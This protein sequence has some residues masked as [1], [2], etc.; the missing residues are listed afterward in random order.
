GRAI[1]DGISVDEDVS[2]LAVSSLVN[3]ESSV[4]YAP[5]FP[6]VF[7]DV[8]SDLVRR[9]FSELDL[10]VLFNQLMVNLNKDVEW[11]AN[12]E[13]VLSQLGLVTLDDSSNRKLLSAHQDMV[14]CLSRKQASVFS[15]VFQAEQF[16]GSSHDS[17]SSDSLD[18]LHKKAEEARKRLNRVH[19][20]A[21]SRTR[22]LIACFDA[23]EQLTYKLQDVRTVL[24][25]LELATDVPD[26]KSPANHFLNLLNEDDLQA[27]ISRLKGT[28]TQAVNSVAEVK[29]LPHLARAFLGCVN[30][31]TKSKNAFREALHDRLDRTEKSK[32]VEEDEQLER[33][34]Y[35]TVREADDR[36]IYLI[37][38]TRE[39]LHRMLLV[40]DKYKD[41]IDELRGHR[42]TLDSIGK[43]FRS[44]D[45]RHTS[46]IQESELLSS[47][48][49]DQL[50]SETDALVELLTQLAPVEHALQMIQKDVFPRLCQQMIEACF[51]ESSVRELVARPLSTELKRA[52]QLR[53]AMDQESAERIRLLANHQTVADTL[54]AI[55]KCV[56]NVDQLLAAP[57]SDDLSVDY[58]A[59]NEADTRLA[60]QHMTLDVT[61]DRV[62]SILKEASREEGAMNK[63][64]WNTARVCTEQIDKLS[65]RLTAAT[66]QVHNRL[67][68][69][70]ASHDLLVKCRREATDLNRWIDLTL[71]L[72]DSPSFLRSSE[73]QLED[74]LNKIRAQIGPRKTQIS[75]IHHL[76]DML[77][78][79]THPAVNTELIAIV[80]D[81][82]S[83]LNQLEHKLD[84]VQQNL[85]SREARH[86]PYAAAV[87]AA[88]DWLVATEGTFNALSPIA[89]SSHELHRQLTEAEQ[90]VDRWKGYKDHMNE[91]YR[92]G[93]SYD[94]SLQFHDC[95]SV[96]TDGAVNP[97]SI[98]PSDVVR[99]MEV[100]R[101]RYA[102]LGT[103]L[104]ERQMEVQKTSKEVAALEQQ[105]QDLLSWLGKRVQ[106]L[107]GQSK[108]LISLQAVEDAITEAKNIHE[109]ISASMSGL[110][111][112]R[113]QASTILHNRGYV[114]GSSELRHAVTD[115][116]RHWSTA[117]NVATERRCR[118]EL[119]VKDAMDFASLGNK[120][121]QQLRQMCVAA[122]ALPPIDHTGLD[123]AP[124][125]LK[126]IRVL[127]KD[128]DSL[129]S[130]L[131]QLRVLGK[132][133]TDRLLPP[134]VAE[135]RVGQTIHELT[136]MY[137]QVKNELATKA[138]QYE[139]ILG[140]T[141]QFEQLLNRITDLVGHVQARVNDP[142][143][144]PTE[145]KEL[146]T[147]MEQ[148][149][150]LLH[151]A[152]ALCDKLC[153]V[154]T[155]PSLQFELKTKLLR[156][157][158]ICAQGD[159][160]VK[161]VLGESDL[162]DANDKEIRNQL[163]QLCGWM[164]EKTSQLDS[165]TDFLCQQTSGVYEV[166]PEM[167][168]Q[169]MN[170]LKT[171]EQELEQ[172]V[173][174]LRQVDSKP[175]VGSASVSQ[176]ELV[177]SQLELLGHAIASKQ[178]QLKSIDSEPAA[179]SVRLNQLELWIES[180]FAELAHPLQPSGAF[181]SEPTQLAASERRFASV[182]D[183]VH[184][185]QVDLE[186][187]RQKL[188]DMATTVEQKP[189]IDTLLAR[190]GVL[191]GSLA[192]L[193]ANTEKRLNQVST[194]RNS[195]NCAQEAVANYRR[196]V[197][198]TETRWISL[199]QGLLTVKSQEH[200]GVTPSA[201][202]DSSQKVELLNQLG[203]LQCELCILLDETAIPDASS[204][205]SPT[206]RVVQTLRQLE[207]ALKAGG[208]TDAR[209]SM[210]GLKSDIAATQQRIEAMVQSVTNDLGLSDGSLSANTTVNL[211]KRFNA[212]FRQ[213][214]AFKDRLSNFPT[215]APGMDPETVRERIQSLNEI[216]ED[217][218]TC[219]NTIGNLRNQLQS[220]TLEGAGVS[221]VPVTDLLNRLERLDEDTSRLD[222]QSRQQ[223]SELDDRLPRTEQLTALRRQLATVVDQAR[224][225][226]IQKSNGCLDTEGDTK[227]SSNTEELIR[228]MQKKLQA[229]RS[230]S[231]HLSGT[232]SDD[233]IQHQLE[234]E[235]TA[236]EH[237]VAQLTEQLTAQ[238][239]DQSDGNVSRLDQMSQNVM[240]LQGNFDKLR[241][242]FDEYSAQLVTSSDHSSARD[243]YRLLQTRVDSHSNSVD[244][245]VALLD[246]FVTND[247]QTAIRK[248]NLAKQLRGMQD[249]CKDLS[250]R[251]QV[252][253]QQSFNAEQTQQQLLDKIQTASAWLSETR[254]KFDHNE[255]AITELNSAADSQ[256]VA[257]VKAQ[258]KEARTN[259]HDELCISG[260]LT[261]VVRFEEHVPVLTDV[262]VPSRTTFILANDMC[263]TPDA[264]CNSLPG[265][266]Y[267][268][269]D[270]HDQFFCDAAAFE[271]W[272]SD[273][274]KQ[275]DC[276]Q[277]TFDEVQKNVRNMSS[278]KDLVKE[279]DARRKTFDSL[280]KEGDLL[281]SSNRVLDA[282]QIREK[283]SSLDDAYLE[284]R[285]D[286]HQRLSAL[287]T[288]LPIIQRLASALATLSLRLPAA[289]SRLATLR[290]NDEPINVKR[291]AVDQLETELTSVLN[292]QAQLV[293]TAWH[294]LQELC[295]PPF[296][297]ARVCVAS[298]RT[299]AEL[300]ASELERFDRFAEQV[301]ELAMTLNSTRHQTAAL[302]S[303]MDAEVLWLDAALKR[304]DPNSTESAPVVNQ[305]AADENQFTG[306]VDAAVELPSEDVD[307]FTKYPPLAVLPAQYESLIRLRDRLA[308][309][310]QGWTKRHAV[311]TGELLVKAHNLLQ[312]SGVRI[313]MPGALQ[314]TDKLSRQLL[315]AVD[316][317]TKRVAQL[318]TRVGQA[319]L[320]IAE[321]SPLAKSFHEDNTELA[322]WLNECEATLEQLTFPGNTA[323]LEEH[324]VAQDL[325]AEHKLHGKVKALDEKMETY[326]TVLDRIIRT[327]SPLIEL[328]GH[329][330]GSVIRAETVR[331][332]ERFNQLQKA[333]RARLVSVETSLKQSDE[334]AEQLNM[335]T[336]LFASIAEQASHLGVSVC[337]GSL[338]T[339]PS[340]TPIDLVDSAQKPDMFESV[341]LGPAVGWDRLRPMV[342]VQ[343]DQ[344]EDQ[345][346]ETKAL[347]EA[348]DQRL[349]ELE[350]LTNC[351]R[352]QLEPKL[353]THTAQRSQD[354][355]SSALVDP[356]TV[357]SARA[358]E[359]HKIILR[360]SEKL[361]T[362][363]LALRNQLQ[364]RV[365]KLSS[366]HE[367]AAKEFWPIVS[368]L[369]G[370]FLEAGETL[371][372]ITAGCR[373]DTPAIRRDPVDPASYVEQRADLENLMQTLAQL[374]AR[375]LAC[376][377]T[378][379]HLI[380]LIS[381]DSPMDD[382]ALKLR[383]EEEQAIRDEVNCALRDLKVQHKNLLTSSQQLANKI[384]KHEIAAKQF[385]AGLDGFI[386]WLSR[387]EVKWD[388][389]EPISNDAT[390]VLKQLE[391]IVTWTDGLL[392]K[393]TELE[394]LN[395][396]ASQLASLQ[397][398]DPCLS[399]AVEPTASLTTLPS[400]LQAD[401]AGANRRWDTLL[402]SGNHRRH[403]L[404]TVLLGLGEFD[405]ALNAL[406]SW[407]RQAQSNIDKI[408]VRRGN[409]RGLEADLARIKVLQ[410]NINN[411]QLAVVRLHDQAK[412]H[413][414]KPEIVSSSAVVSTSTIG[415]SFENMSTTER[416]V[417][418][419]TAW[420][421][422]KNSSREKQQ[423][424]EEALRETFNFHGHFD[425]LVRRCR[426]LE[427]RLPSAGSRTMGCLPDSA[428]DQLRRFMEVYDGLVEIG[429]EL[430]DLRKTSAALLVSGASSAEEAPEHLMGAL[431][432]F[433]DHHTQ[434]L[435]RA[436]AIR[437]QLRTSL[438]E[439]EQFHI[440]L[441]E[442]IKWLTLMERTLAQQ[443]PVSRI[444]A[445]LGPLILEHTS[446]RKDIT[447]HREELL[448]LDRMAA[449]IQCNAQKQDTVLV[450]N[451]LAS[452]HN[453]WEQLLSRSA[454]RTRHLNIGLKEAQTF[455]NNWTSL[456]DW[457]KEQ[458]VSLEERSMNIATRPE[459]VAHQLAQHRE[460]QRALGARN[461]AFD[462]TRRYARHLRDRAP[463]CDHAELDDMI[464]ELKHLWHTVCSLSLDRHRALEEALLSA[465]LYKEALQSLGDWLAKVEPQLAEHQVGVFGDVETVEQLIDAHRRLTNEL[466]QRA[467]WIASVRE[468]AEDLMAKAGRNT[469]GQ[470]DVAA[471]RGQVNHV[472]GVWNRVQMLSEKRG[473]RLDEALKLAVQ[474]QEMCR[475]LMDY[476]A[477][478]EHVIR[479]LAA[480]PTYDD[481]CEDEPTTTVGETAASTKVA[482]FDTGAPESLAGAIEAHKQTH[483]NL[484]DQA[485]RVEATLQLGNQLLT[486][487]HPEAIP[488]LR[489]WIHTLQSRWTDLVNW[490][491]QRGDR[492]QIATDEQRRRKLL[493]SE[494]M[495]WIT[496][497]QRHVDR[498][499]TITF[500]DPVKDATVRV[501]SANGHIPWDLKTDKSEPS[502]VEVSDKVITVSP[503]V[504]EASTVATFRTLP[505]SEITE[506]QLI[507][508]LLSEQ[509]ELE[510][511]VEVR[512][513]VL[514]SI[515]KHAKRRSI[516]RVPVP[517]TSTVRRG[518][519]AFK[520]PGR[521][522]I[523]RTS[524]PVNPEPT[525]VSASANHLYHRWNHLERSLQNRRS[526]L[527]DRLAYLKEVEKMKN[528]QFENWRQRY[529]AWLNQNKARV[530]DLF[531][532]KDKDRDGRLT[533][534]EFIDGILEMKFQTNRVELQAVAEIFDANGDG[535]I[536]YRECMDALRAGYVAS[537]LAAYSGSSQLSLSQIG[538]TDEEAINDEVR[539][540]VG[541]CTCHNTYQICK[542][543]NNT[544]RFGNSQKLR[545]VRILRSAVMVRVGGGWV[546]LDE[547]LAKNDPCRGSCQR[548]S[549]FSDLAAAVGLGPSA[550][551][552]RRPYPVGYPSF[553][554]DLLRLPTVSASYSNPLRSS[555]ESST[556][557]Q[558]TANSDG[559][560]GLRNS[561]ACSRH[562]SFRP[563]FGP[564]QDNA[565]F[566]VMPCTKANPTNH[567]SSCTSQASSLTSLP[568]RARQRRHLGKLSSHDSSVS[569][570]AALN[571]SE[572]A[573]HPPCS[574]T[575]ISIDARGRRASIVSLPFP[576]SQNDSHNFDTFDSQSLS[577]VGR[578]VIDSTVA[579]RSSRPPSRLSVTSSLPGASTSIP[580]P[581]LYPTPKAHCDCSANPPNK[582]SSQASSHSDVNE[583]QPDQSTDSLRS[584]TRT[585]C[586]SLTSAPLKS[587]TVKSSSVPK[588]PSKSDITSSHAKK[589]HT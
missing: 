305:S 97:I 200:A 520:P 339:R 125:H 302:L 123:S 571:R 30:R 119:L 177:K 459:A 548:L 375:L 570:V 471:I 206:V 212:M 320:R 134:V 502:S 535:Y 333:V 95:M 501:A 506:P 216:H 507:E 280:R 47:N 463:A 60:V 120:L 17:M 242:D 470:L 178:M 399:S 249:G 271:S 367:T 275:L 32:S 118:L 108:R 284:L 142:P 442:M 278:L 224:K 264:N 526:R 466:N 272:L 398:D 588:Q 336:D 368:E 241:T 364:S 402:D 25:Q 397:L 209:R 20:E 205:P 27:E 187:I 488:R 283:L 14:D 104:H 43:K 480:L 551:R 534:S 522:P 46:V 201:V 117:L 396:A 162:P 445:R 404:Q 508:R 437:D 363:W 15:V 8:S 381:L 259:G 429:N 443:K 39:R 386:E 388:Q 340:T 579:D 6:G 321:A 219:K 568:V 317:V 553:C 460:F 485:E 65:K 179:L 223:M 109:E 250:D 293:R 90:L 359:L 248:D 309:F 430:S 59:F 525:F 281:I 512:R 345:L 444:V 313:G 410:N 253:L 22:T 255:P 491:S 557:S 484:M 197:D 573:E 37:E 562:T 124:S 546:N 575:N 457:L 154:T 360:N 583:E 412:K 21:E 464:T 330:D 89:L 344:L 180:Q 262:N 328:V 572:S 513:S 518:R 182:L 431:D 203:D 13:E 528:F 112:F 379:D 533:Y 376:D 357:D 296:T 422:L 541:L 474:F 254:D 168:K 152:R 33:T 529:V 453:R 316:L 226:Y 371:R 362:D 390:T 114:S 204:P 373:L 11:I 57:S 245:L 514:E 331:V 217:L 83:R 238:V 468:T 403:R 141:F 450:K 498:E 523:S 231:R 93:A 143:V 304:L 40:E 347:L 423:L 230:L 44:T 225:A 494:L 366:V 78:T 500:E 145:A 391:E 26:E 462:A 227:Q 374:S 170:T 324:P 18:R 73:R 385:K 416:L 574:T 421:K 387:Q 86:T 434:V 413:V 66:E 252:Q 10:D 286:V 79:N 240:R 172:N 69:L 556:G 479:R 564:D 53:E 29:S 325:D 427:A 519:S 436:A 567:M 31:Y 515:L 307:L 196:A 137:D 531:H 84:M 228:Q 516:S 185:K 56:E 144:S 545:M 469:T 355:D 524:E 71:A 210:A 70:T 82:E 377:K 207:S 1:C 192:R 452:V 96:T 489:Q 478:A 415:D 589:R 326:K 552:L 433:V 127:E 5:F 122:R 315:L 19:Q 138:G 327:S 153:A 370:A 458:V 102:H 3:L 543:T 282:E 566:L 492:L 243:N 298:N 509:T 165:L 582:P 121:S 554:R 287:E 214:Q 322:D 517:R 52:A 260:S 195:Y 338:Q 36:F 394:A 251:I 163:E 183:A 426:Q 74:G 49:C 425:R 496:T 297:F 244:H 62:Q 346:N 45:L 440:E 81:L 268:L 289:E 301:S 237:V 258:L 560:R 467:D 585:I 54:D 48:E 167:I 176:F 156:A 424:L 110:D 236:A 382:G 550:L 349:P 465:G 335:M 171:I 157:E 184:E 358:I 482:K 208:D 155:D 303:K 132:R 569:S 441:A 486:Q 308:Q 400:S 497:T 438:N 270:Q 50:R 475:S 23:L 578:T 389:F 239:V 220:R 549:S 221:A 409:I 67:Q 38:K 306:V 126:E 544:Y 115:T 58:T 164:S 246:S 232:Y 92:L 499:P 449:H 160:D 269:H 348:L 265:G 130:D 266:A 139:A 455:L 80:S 173:I 247:Q 417:L 159:A 148:A 351:V 28:M 454:E 133:L 103:R 369:H 542:T 42:G 63:T 565:F 256:L 128:L 151:K 483:A 329:N 300:I 540:Q 51:S 312:A 279:V 174:A 414:T 561:R 129:T 310:R 175:P 372:L 87:Q 576:A 323:E 536:D 72:L 451:L 472:N 188:L 435:R 378:G 384:D 263:S 495:E 94:S 288:A 343:P 218:A 510:Q 356:F 191:N 181:L 299:H 105:Q 7:A 68:N 222:Q 527:Q 383:S 563:I 257:N 41:F 146:E 418:M 101:E 448:A 4:G 461:I 341:N 481:V 136:S 100:M 190:T 76:I 407:M 361:Q 166:C 131:G 294:R 149:L 447:S 350:A 229:M 98:E 77:P 34:V 193:G 140:P 559:A 577:G 511:E 16:I 476:F 342:S 64:D 75:E 12:C 24:R 215:N 420:E 539:R 353:L 505:L 311:D 352:A 291:I 35:G 202:P 428:R 111:D 234:A 55:T 504:G 580:K 277:L 150:H 113:Q 85:N 558:H 456:T 490:S 2:G 537:R 147:F 584:A 273:C 189:M 186:Q 135:L 276:L 521:L 290:D 419:N 581:K 91:V 493:S 401:L 213:I 61:R 314:T 107:V 233:P 555:A 235:I 99:E 439:V 169:Q 503:S 538:R 405:H 395:W 198:D 194:I 586:S 477:G 274:A 211:M 88:E 530:V 432:R 267:Q 411:H 9:P 318:D 365:R 261:K 587:S 354:S 337:P 116:E 158:N 380:H 446:F 393:H 473:K 285:S 547:F 332:T 292:P 199:Q 319:E 295:L 161:Q 106:M 392:H 487:A 532:R 408:P 334:I 406:I